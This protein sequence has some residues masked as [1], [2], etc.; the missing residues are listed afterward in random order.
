MHM[1]QWGKE[2]CARFK[3]AFLS[4]LPRAILIWTDLEN[5]ALQPLLAAM[6]MDV[7]RQDGQ[8]A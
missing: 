5:Y 7:K 1:T 8:A 6:M 3:G 4:P 2:Y